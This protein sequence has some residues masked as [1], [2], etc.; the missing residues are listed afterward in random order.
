M[1][2]TI[3]SIAFI[4]IAAACISCS[5]EQ[6]PSS[7]VG[8]LSIGIS[9]PDSPVRAAMSSN[10]L[11]SSA[12]VK[13]YKADFSGLVREYVY[14]DAPSVIYLPVDEYR[15]DVQAGEIAK[16]S[17]SPASWEQKSYEGSANFVIKP[18]VQSNVQV[19]AK[20]ANVVTKVTF[21]QTIAENF[22]AGFTFRIG[23]SDSDATCQLVYNA[24]NSGSEG[25]F[26]PSDIEPALYWS[27]SGTLKNGTPVVKTGTFDAVQVGKL[28]KIAPKFTVKDGAVDFNLLVD[29]NTEVIEDIIIFD[30]VSTG[31]SA[32]SVTDIWA[33]HF[34]V[35]ADVDE[36]EYS[37]P[38]KV[39]I[40]YSLKGKG[41]W[42]TVATTRTGEGVYTC[43][44]NGLAPATEYDVKL[45][46]DGTDINTINVTT[47]A[48]KQL[49]NWDFEVTS[50]AESSK[51]TSFYDPANSD[52]ELKTKF[53]DSGS[54][55]S[56]GMLGASYAICYS[57]SD[58]SGKTASKKSVRMQSLAAA[59]KLAAGN[60][61]TG[62][63]A[64]LDGLNGK[65][66]FGRPWG[67][68][69]PTAVRFWYKYKGG[70]V[71]KTA[72][73]CPLTTSD[74]DRFSIKVA[75]G[76]W[77]FKKYGGTKN[78]PVQV[79]TNKTST[80]WDYKKIEG[81]VAYCE[82]VE[83]GNGSTG[84]WKQV[85][86]PLDYFSTSDFPSFIVVAGAASMYGDYF[87]G[88]SSSAL[89]IDDFELLYE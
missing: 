40:A 72:S 87:A 68:Y 18:S 83:V 20:V 54:S 53:W 7:G 30:P 51:W 34:T 56:A 42:I 37:D 15:V 36:K 6:L 17:P 82:L 81:T 86:I 24:T 4:V 74:Y 29:Y 78:C 58:V 65:V 1:K 21:D 52:P 84:E 5:R 71:D 33:G 63:F 11:L 3:Y 41:A 9:V 35:M 10:E 16:A 69:R 70:K 25:Y 12:S 57:D 22:N 26:I 44:L 55:A 28:Y 77:D 89:W 45:V 73:G 2:K 23:L 76:N 64:G 79:N 75:L 88:S 8:S 85:T 50:N 13:I 67:Q 61:F 66:N 49:P 60:L 47:A 46:I 32:P 59:G 43:T 62:E 38:S 19:N 27:F 80:F 14:K 31:V 48:A 39:K